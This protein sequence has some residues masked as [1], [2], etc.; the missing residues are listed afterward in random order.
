M[1]MKHVDKVVRIREVRDYVIPIYD[2]ESD[3]LAKEKAM[4]MV[5]EINNLYCKINKKVISVD[6]K[7]WKEE[8]GKFIS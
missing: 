3:E 2:E 4:K 1:T 8:D 5:N 6:T 7:K